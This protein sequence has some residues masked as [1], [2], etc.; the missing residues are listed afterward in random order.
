MAKDT[1]LSKAAQ[2]LLEYARGLAQARGDGLVDTDHFLLALFRKK[3][4]N[5]FFKWLEKTMSN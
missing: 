2:G 5:P 4:D 3:E 1:K